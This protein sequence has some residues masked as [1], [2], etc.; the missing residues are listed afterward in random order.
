[1]TRIERYVMLRLKLINVAGIDNKELD[2]S[3]VIQNVDQ[4]EKNV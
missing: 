1:M 2:V 4:G 3:Y